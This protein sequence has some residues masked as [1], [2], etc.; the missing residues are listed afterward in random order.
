MEV[1]YRKIHDFSDEKPE[2]L[3]NCII[4]WEGNNEQLNVMF[5]SYDAD[6]NLFRD[7]LGGIL[8]GN[9]VRYWIYDTECVITI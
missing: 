2:E 1:K 5:G 7:G 4:L 8:E 9:H 3:R 6:M